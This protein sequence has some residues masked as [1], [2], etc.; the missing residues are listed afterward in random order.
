ML[1]KESKTKTVVCESPEVIALV[2]LPCQGMATI[3]LKCQA[4]PAEPI[5]GKGIL[6]LSSQYTQEQQIMGKP[7]LNLGNCVS[8]AK[9][10]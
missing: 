4:I 8:L 9:I 3:A 5:R 2:S 1:N 10:Y 6:Y 7:Q